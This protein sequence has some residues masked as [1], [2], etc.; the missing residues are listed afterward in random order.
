F[1]GA[2]LANQGFLR[3][4]SMCQLRSIDSQKPTRQVEMFE[5]SPRIDVWFSGDDVKA[6]AIRHEFLDGLR[7]TRIERVV[8]HPASLES[9]AKEGNRQVE[10]VNVRSIKQRRKRSVERWPNLGVDGGG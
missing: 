7:D 4:V 8:E 2:H 1:C 3:V 5:D 9:L 10:S 6:E